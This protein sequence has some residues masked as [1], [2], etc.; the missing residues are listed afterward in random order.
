MEKFT[1]H[2]LF[3]IIVV[4]A[5]LFLGGCHF[6][7]SKT[8]EGTHKRTDLLFVSVEKTDTRSRELDCRKVLAMGE[9]G[10]AD[11]LQREVYQTC[12]NNHASRRSDPVPVTGSENSYAARYNN[13]MQV[14]YGMYYGHPLAAMQQGRSSWGV[15]GGAPGLPPVATGSGTASTAPSQGG[16]SPEDFGTL[17]KAVVQQGRGITQLRDK[18]ERLERGEKPPPSEPAGSEVVDPYGN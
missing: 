2:L 8:P 11:M 18:V 16:V 14:P 5:S 10:A 12:F 17:T 15:V 13:G 7:E 6:S 1:K 4:L 9:D 3:T